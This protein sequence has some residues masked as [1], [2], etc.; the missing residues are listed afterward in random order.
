MFSGQALKDLQKQLSIREFLYFGNAISSFRCLT[1]HSPSAKC[2][3]IFSMYALVYFLYVYFYYLLLL[4]HSR[5]EEI[6][7]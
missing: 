6:Y 3:K 5:C 2:S 4:L 1:I 7:S